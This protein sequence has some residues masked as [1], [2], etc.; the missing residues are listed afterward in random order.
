MSDLVLRIKKNNNQEFYNSPVQMPE[1]EY[2]SIMAQNVFSKDPILS[3][4]LEIMHMV[5]LEE[6]FL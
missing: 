4:H 1:Q 3:K 2:N 6:V 5:K